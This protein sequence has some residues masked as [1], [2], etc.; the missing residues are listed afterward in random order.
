[1]YFWQQGQNVQLLYKNLFLSIYLDQILTWYF[2]ECIV[3][4]ETFRAR[5]DLMLGTKIERNELWTICIYKSLFLLRVGC[6]CY[7]VEY[8]ASRANKCRILII[9]PYYSGLEFICTYWK[10]LK[11]SLICFLLNL[12]VEPKNG[13]KFELFLSKLYSCDLNSFGNIIKQLFTFMSWTF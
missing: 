11:K 3:Y 13:L 2:I 4:I 5:R 12:L 7:K 6:S 1:M 9:G 10:A 8:I